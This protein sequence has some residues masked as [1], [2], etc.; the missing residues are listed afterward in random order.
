MSFV[1]LSKSGDL[2]FIRVREGVLFKGRRSSMMKR[3]SKHHIGDKRH[4]VSELK[5][6]GIF[7]R[8]ER[9]TESP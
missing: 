7:I 2:L 6:Q 8:K 4:T 5:K 3:A 9:Y 1:Y